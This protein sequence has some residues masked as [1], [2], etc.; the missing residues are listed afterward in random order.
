MR[1]FFRYLGYSLCAAVVV[2]GVLYLF[3]LRLDRVGTGMPVLT[4][5]ESADDHYAQIEARSKAD[6]A[7]KPATVPIATSTPE[8]SKAAEAPAAEPESAKPA[9]D[10]APWPLFYGPRQDGHYRGGPIRTS[11]PSGGLEQLWKRPI[12]G[13]Y[14]SMVVA[15]SKVFTI[16]QRRQQEAATAYDLAT[17]RE[18]WVNGW[19]AFFQE[20]MGG[21]GPRATPAY[22]DGRLYVLG[23]MGEFRCLDAA[24]GRTLWRKN[25]LEDNGASNIQW[26]M[27]S[28]PLVVDDLVIV[29]PGG[30][31]GKSV[32]AYDRVTGGK[33][34]TALDDKAA[35]TA[36]MLATLAGQRQI[37]IVTATRA[38]GLSLDGAKVLWEFPWVT[39]YD[40]NSALPVIVDEN[41]VLLSAGYGHGSALIEIT[42][43][44]TKEVWKSNAMKAKFN[45]VVLKDGVIYGLDDGILAAMDLKTGQR[46]WKGGRYG[47]GQ[48]L[49][50]GDHLVI[51]SEQGEVVLVKAIPDRH[52]EVA[53][54]ESLDGKTWNVPAMADGKLIVR[55]ETQ[56]ACY[57]I[58]R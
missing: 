10:P 28:S 50:A 43:S 6:Q 32:A 30:P 40:V 31:G 16:E 7:M 22:Q 26:G 20:S 58:E 39:D 25:I 11:W 15:E 36:P 8:P 48:L 2:L 4:F 56:M 57:R 9:G 23:A 18:I 45:N 17:G 41:H 55:N 5:K 29:L 35:Y 1:R 24:T 14:A 44:G 52:E 19:D 27:S 51:A 3:G 21:N 49:L 47:F 46:K 12:G 33:R 42:P 34:W 38:L 54:F 53:Q 13:G 37:V